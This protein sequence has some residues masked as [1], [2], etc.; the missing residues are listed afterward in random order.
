MDDPADLEL[1]LKRRN[2]AERAHAFRQRKKRQEE[3]DRLQLVQQA[4]GKVN[5]ELIDFFNVAFTVQYF[6]P[7][8][9]V[10]ETNFEWQTGFKSR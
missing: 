5:L 8:F 7:R 9:V 1:Q 3:R 6:N 2:A 4:Y 10:H